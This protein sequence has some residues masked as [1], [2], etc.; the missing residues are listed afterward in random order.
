MNSLRLAVGGTV[1]AALAARASGGPAFNLFGGFHH[2][3]PGVGGGMCALNDVATAI[4]ELR[5]DGMTGQI[6]VLDLDAHPPDGLSAC[7]A[8]DPHVRIG[9]ISGSEWSALP[10][11]VDETFLPGAEDAPYLAALTSLLARLPRPELVFVISGGDVLSGDRLG[12]LALTLD[13]ARERDLEVAAWAEHAPSVWLPAGGYADASWKVLVGTYLA[14]TRKSRRP[15]K[16]K[17]P[18][19]SR[20]AAIA[21]GLSKERLTGTVSENDDWSLADVEE[22]LFGHGRSEVKLLGFYTTEGIE[23]ALARYGGFD[24]L[25]RLGYRD[26]RIHID[27]EDDVGQRVTVHGR[28][29]GTEHLLIDLI[30]GRDQIAGAPVLVVHWLSLRNPRAAFTD[31]RRPLPGQEFPGLGLA[32][33]MGQLLG[34]MAERLGLTAVALRPAYLH[35]AYAA[36][37]HFAFVDAERQ[38]RFVWLLHDLR[39]RPLGEISRALSEGRVRLDGKPYAWEADLMLYQPGDV[40]PSLQRSPEE[41]AEPTRPRFTLVEA[42]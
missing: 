31:G 28:A 34:Q 38:A 35:T 6:V 16:D 21:R 29:E 19:M 9:S 13:G 41:S 5:A 37:T 33:D 30:V 3:G 11:N 22:E 15:V 39:P 1:A 8:D 36:R 32:R 26:L 18:L 12:K 20:F 7:L 14:V 27:P 24:H 25:R 42:L 10:S 40:P 23:Y 4:A 17:D 2:A